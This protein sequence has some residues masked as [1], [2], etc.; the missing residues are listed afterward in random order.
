M[1][2][3]QVTVE[4]SKE[5]QEVLAALV[6]IV[7]ASKQAL[8]DGFQPGADLPAIVAAAWAKLPE[9]ISGLDQ[10]PAEFAEDKAALV[11][12]VLLGGSDLVDA[13]LAK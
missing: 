12:T 1:A 2:K 7:K 4:V 10:V 5:T 9:A 8:A 3:I 11:R 13:L 6:E